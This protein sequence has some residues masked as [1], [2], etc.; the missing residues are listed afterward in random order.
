MEGD[1]P[2]EEGARPQE[3]DSPGGPVAKMLS[4]QL[5][6]GGQ[7]SI[8]AQG[9][10]SHMPPLGPSTAKQIILKKN[11]IKE[12][13]RREGRA[14]E[15]VWS[16]A[17]ASGLLASGEGG[18]EAGPHARACSSAYDTRLRQRVAVKKLSRPF[19]SLIHARRTYRELRLLKHLKHENVSGV[20]REGGG[21][22]RGRGRG[23]AG[24]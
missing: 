17:G 7:S 3:G 20:G 1:L 10:R 23:G 6:R 5:W 14:W 18:T 2:L 12:D 19:Q 4:S 9:T 8:P 11:K 15:R 22:A 16:D 24:L 21:G 13:P